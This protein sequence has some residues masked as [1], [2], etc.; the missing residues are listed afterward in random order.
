MLFLDL[1]PLIHQ[2]LVSDLTPCIS[3]I[4]KVVY[5]LIKYGAALKSFQGRGNDAEIAGT[6]RNV[7]F[8]NKEIYHQIPYQTAVSTF[9]NGFRKKL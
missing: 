7:P 8:Q 5:F 4:L 9:Q 6:T 3:E 1:L 2:T